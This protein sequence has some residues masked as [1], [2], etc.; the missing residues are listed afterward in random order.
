[1]KT[2]SLIIALGLALFMPAAFAQDD[3]EDHSGHHPGETNQVEKSQPPGNEDAAARAGPLQKSMTDLEGLMQQ[4]QETGDPAQK[5]LLLNEHLQ[6]LRDQMRLIRSQHTAMR[7]SMGDDTR[8]SDAMKEGMK[9]KGGMMGG[10]MMMHK[11][12]E[13]RLDMLERM[14]Q[15]VIEREAVEQSVEQ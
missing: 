8:K 10:M 7:M 3:E 4:I 1:M 6:A 5:R 12:V 9:Q 13:Q 11:K 15:Q 2:L 14:L